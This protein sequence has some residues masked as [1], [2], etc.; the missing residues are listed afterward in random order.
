M[1]NMFNMLNMLNI[2]YIIVKLM[3]QRKIKI[4]FLDNKILLIY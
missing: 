3:Q 1:F 2:L 4:L